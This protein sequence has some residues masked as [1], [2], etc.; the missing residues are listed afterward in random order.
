MAVAGAIVF[1]AI[2]ALALVPQLMRL[3]RLERETRIQQPEWSVR[4]KRA[5]WA[6]RRRVMRAMRHGETLYDREDARLLVGLSRRADMYH[7]TAGRRWV[8]E[9]LFIAAALIFGVA[10]RSLGLTVETL[11]VL[12]AGLLF[13]GV[14]LPRQ[15]ERRRRAA[16]ANEQL[17]GSL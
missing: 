9:G 8:F 12:G 7:Q 4:W 13:R 5:G 16:A 17:H 2:A 1:V 14:L 6:R 11:V 15:R 10:T 3:I